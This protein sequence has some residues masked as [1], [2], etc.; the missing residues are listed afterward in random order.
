MLTKQ[1]K[2]LL[3]ER[4]AS[5]GR[6]VAKE[7]A[8][9]FGLSD[10]TIRRDLRELAAAGKLQRV[11]GGALPSAPAEADLIARQAIASVSKK[12]VG[13]VAAGLIK[14]NSVV[15]VDGGTTTL[16][17]IN[18]LPLDVACTV[19]THSPSVAMALTEHLAIKVV[20]I[21]GV[22]YRHSMVNVGSAAIEAMSHI[23][24]D[25]FFMGV[26]G[27]SIEEGL[28]T[29][30]LEE[31]HVKR[32][33]SQ[34]AAETIVLASDEKLGVASPYVIMPVNKATGIVLSDRPEKKLAKALTRLQLDVYT[35]SPISK[36]STLA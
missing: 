1:R 18:H 20:M 9:E 7:L 35:A 12:R 10:D 29:G 14:P 23:R 6:I 13:K 15:I 3:L 22:L 24:A 8:L 30:D 28:S 2:S 25:C 31:A 19:V 27:V 36:I 26:T 32:A 33:L 4:L 21:G 17:M 16:Q 34:R 11:H 5:D